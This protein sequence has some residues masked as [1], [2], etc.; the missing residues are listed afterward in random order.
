MGLA[1]PFQGC[2]PVLPQRL[3]RE[4]EVRAEGNNGAQEGEGAWRGGY[5]A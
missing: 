5:K 2:I 1:L 3:Q 4:G